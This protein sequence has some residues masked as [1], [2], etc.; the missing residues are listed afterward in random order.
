MKKGYISVIVPAYN[1]EEYLGKCLDSI[2]GQE[3][4]EIE[5][6]LIN[7]GSSDHTAQICEHYARKEPRI[8]YME[9]PNHGIAYTRKKAVGLASGQYIG[10]VDADDF[11][12]ETMY[13]QMIPYMEKAQLVT[14]GYYYQKGKVFDA[15]PEGLYEGQRAKKYLYENML[16]FENTCKIGITTNL[17]SK[18]FLAQKLKKAA[19]ES[20]ENL[21]VG[22]DADILFR[23]ILLCD[24]VY[25]SGICAYHHESTA[26][27]I[28]NTVN[29]SYLRNVDCLYR[30][31]TEV[32]EESAYGD[33]ILPEWNRWIW[34]MLQNAPQFMGWQIEKPKER[35]RYISPYMNLLSGKKVILYGAGAVGKDF[36]RLHKS[37]KDVEIILWT[38]QN[39]ERLQKEGFDVCATEKI[40]DVNFD[41]IILAV[42]GREAADLIGVQLRQ[43]GISDA[44][45]LWKKPVEIDD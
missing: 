19:A 4:K 38:D 17:W 21:F 23:Y 8:V 26:D 10:F 28:M 41:Y 25:I 2:I 12:D 9:Q 24:S 20:T 42:K 31:L 44:K 27:S 33:V 6:I 7:D 43:R 14:S 3:Y 16:F 37:S 36:Y 13:G 18:L 1:C 30:S 29:R 11:I 32:F 5:I 40:C 15:V 34:M 35:I 45:I 22:E 39:W